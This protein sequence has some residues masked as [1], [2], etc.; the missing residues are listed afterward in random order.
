[1]AL[2]KIARTPALYLVWFC[3]VYLPRWITFS[4]SM[5]FTKS[6]RVILPR[7]N[8]ASYFLSNGWFRSSVNQTTLFKAESIHMASHYRLEAAFILLLS[9]FVKIQS[10]CTA[11]ILLRLYNPGLLQ[12]SH[13]YRVFIIGKTSYTLFN[14]ALVLVPGALGLF[15]RI[16]HTSLRTCILDVVPRP[17]SRSPR[18]QRLSSYVGSDSLTIH[19]SIFSSILRIFLT[20]T[21]LIKTNQ[22]EL[23]LLLRA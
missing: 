22:A 13:Y 17:V 15:L 4:Q 10:F 16:P 23:Y 12:Y 14:P 2:F 8:F 21:L 11:R 19:S 9:F 5:T 18:S 7:G 1:M 6:H 3:A 20:L